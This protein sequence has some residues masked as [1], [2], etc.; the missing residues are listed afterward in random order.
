MGGKKEYINF[1]P[2]VVKGIAFAIDA[3]TEKGDNIIIQPPVYHPFRLVPQ[4]LERTVVNNPLIL[5]D[6]RYR[7]DLEGLRNILS[8]QKGKMFILCSPHNP[9]GRVWDAAELRELAEI[10][11]DNGVMVLSD[12]IH[13][14]MAF[15]G[16]RHIPFATVSKKAE[17]ISLTLMAPSKTF[18]IAGIVSSFAVIPNK[19]IRDKIP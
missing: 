9:G 12:E 2:G 13:C 17:E 15:S 8:R 4:A 10:C 3:F 6:G 19:K 1:V 18:N 7:M 16:F 5:E 14:D 11:Y